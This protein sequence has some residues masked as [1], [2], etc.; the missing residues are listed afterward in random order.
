[1]WPNN[2]RD[3]VSPVHSKEIWVIANLGLG[4]KFQD[5]ARLVCNAL[6]KEGFYAKVVDSFDLYLQIG[7]DNRDLLAAVKPPVAAII[8]VKDTVL[9]KALESMG[10]LT[11]N[12]S[13][14][15]RVCD[16]KSLTHLALSQ[17]NVPTPTT[18]VPPERYPG[19][20]IPEHFIA[21]AEELIGYPMIVKAAK[22]SFGKEVFMAQSRL[23]LENSLTKLQHKPLIIQRFVRSTHNTD[24]RVQVI[25]GKAMAA[26]QRR[27]N[28]GD[29]RANLTLGASGES[30]SPSDDVSRTAEMASVAVGT[31]SAGVDLIVD[32]DGRPL[33]LEVNSN[34]H[35]RR[36]T[37]ITGVQ[38]ARLFAQAV[39]RHLI[40]IE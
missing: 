19:Q 4:T 5:Q 3:Y 11:F 23:E 10:V 37:E 6:M 35:L 18:L 12:S 36:I 40:D 29:F 32:I 39:A 31:L 2:I 16:D 28:N 24:L 9:I 7:D 34:A 21:Y 30:I 38:V 1:M 13:E 17:N 14:A 15:V 25:D 20:P 26:V 8:Q 33:V 22:G 27:P